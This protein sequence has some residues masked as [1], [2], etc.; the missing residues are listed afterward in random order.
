MPPKHDLQPLTDM[1][2]A[3][4]VP[5][6]PKFAAPYPRAAPDRKRAKLPRTRDLQHLTDLTRAGAVPPRCA[7]QK[8]FAT[9]LYGI[10]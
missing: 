4:A 7:L 1:T 3:G 5:L 8:T 10:L 9:E 6:P 2:R